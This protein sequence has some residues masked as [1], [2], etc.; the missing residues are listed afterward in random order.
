MAIPPHLLAELDQ[1]SPSSG[2]PS[3]K[4]ALILASAR[5]LFL[6]RGYGAT[7]MDDIARQARV[8]KATVYEYFAGKDALFAAMVGD[9]CQRHARLIEA[10]EAK[11]SDLRGALLQFAGNL[12]QFL[13]SPAAISIYRQVLAEASR[14]PSLGVTF[15]EAGPVRVRHHLARFLAV[16]A[17]QGQLE[18]PDPDRAA[19]DFLSLVRGDVQMRVLFALPAPS[20]PELDTLAQLAVDRFLKAYAPDPA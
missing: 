9:Q 8:S 14:S 17:A 4:K 2:E 13:M 20:E 16:V 5:T 18:I 10:I 15:Y 11:G 1:D 6:D 3:S 12:L 7:S 19:I